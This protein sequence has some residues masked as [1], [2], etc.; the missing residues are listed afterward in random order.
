[1]EVTV[2]IGSLCT[3][4][5][6]NILPIQSCVIDFSRNTAQRLSAEITATPAHIASAMTT[7]W[8]VYSNRV[9]YIVMQ[10]HRAWPMSG[11]LLYRSQAALTLTVTGQ[12]SRCYSTAICLGV[13]IT[14]LSRMENQL[15][16]HCTNQIAYRLWMISRG[17]T[18]H[19]TLYRSFRG[20]FLQV[21]WPNQQRQSTEGSQLAAEI[22]FNP[23]R[24]T[25]L[26]YNMN[27]R[28]PPLG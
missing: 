6:C 7:R 19:S 17:L 4:G 8:Q 28:Q 15:Q 20:R 27:C 14:A 26:C 21:R 1:M 23:T 18:S 24:T 25:P 22:G 11:S 10:L 16:S 5:T 9:V 13:A 2:L 12:Q 3:K